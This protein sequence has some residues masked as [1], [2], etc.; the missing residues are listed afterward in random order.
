MLHQLRE[1]ASEALSS[2]RQI[3]LS[4]CGPADIQAEVLP[5]ESVGLAL[6]V[7]V[8]WRSDLLFNLESSTLVV[9]TAETWQVRGEAR[10]LSPGEYPDG[11]A[12]TR[13]P[14][15][16]WCQLVEIRP[17]R[18]QLRSPQGR[19]ETIDISTARTEDSPGANE[20]GDK[21]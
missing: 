3:V 11:L 4:A 2:A 18:L 12:I 16:A 8:P 14:E 6:Y 5:C 1:Q 20:H 21:R 9:G 7:L 17:S 13:T 10:L 15:A 19:G